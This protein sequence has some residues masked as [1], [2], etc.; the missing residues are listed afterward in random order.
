[1]AEFCLFIILIVKLSFVSTMLQKCLKNYFR[2]KF[3]ICVEVQTVDSEIVNGALTAPTN[4]L[5]TFFLLLLDASR[6]L[7][8]ITFTV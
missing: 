2:H 7:A 3:E 6:Y 5:S 4:L 1:M 8:K